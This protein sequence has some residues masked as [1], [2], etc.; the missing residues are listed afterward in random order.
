MTQSLSQNGVGGRTYLRS[1][2][3]RYKGSSYTVTTLR[4]GCMCTWSY[5]PEVSSSQRP[6]E[7]HASGYQEL[8]SSGFL[9]GGPP[10]CGAGVILQ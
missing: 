2:G 7:A 9:A 4:H 3:S 5:R 6:R 10:S 1:P 8:L